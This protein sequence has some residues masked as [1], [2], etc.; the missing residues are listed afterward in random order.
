MHEQEARAEGD[1]LLVGLLGETAAADAHREA[2]VIADQRARPDLSSDAA[3][4]HHEDAQPLRG[5]VHGR[6]QPRGPGAHDD[7]VEVILLHHGATSDELGD[8]GI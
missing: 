2:E 5:A 4:V 6:R 7:H 1:R 3:F 8:L